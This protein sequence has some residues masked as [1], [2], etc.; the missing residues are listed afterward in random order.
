MV[1]TAP[2]RVERVWI[3]SFEMSGVS[4]LGGLGEAVGLL[5]RG[6]ARHGLK[7]TVVMPSHGVSPPGFVDRGVRCSGLRRGADGSHHHYSIGFLEGFVDGVRVLLLHGLDPQTSSILDAWPHYSNVEEK[8]SLL[9]RGALCLVGHEGFPDLVHAN[10]WHAVP[11]AVALKLAAEERGYSLPTVFQVHLR[12]SASFPWHYASGEWSG[13]PNI[14]HRVWAVTHHTYR[15]TKEVWDWCGGSVECF[16]IYEADA[17]VAVSRSVVDELARSYGGWLWG[18]S[19]YSYNSTEWGV[20]ELRQF[21]E[22][23]YGTSSR[24]V[25]RWRLVSEVLESGE[26]WGWLNLS[27][28]EVLALSSGR[29]TSQK[30]F[31]TLLT[32]TKY[33]PPGVRVLI[34]GLRVGSDPYEHYVRELAEGLGGRAAVVYRRLDHMIYKALHYVAHLYVM[35][36]RYEPFGISAI[37]AMAVG[38][39]I[40]ATD[41]GG[42]S[43]YVAD[44][45][46]SPLGVGL[47][48]PPEDPL[49]LAKAI[50]SL[51]YLMHISEGGGGLEYVTYPE[52]R[53]IAA[54]EPRYGDL[55]RELTARYVEIFFRPKH[56][57]NSVLKC[58]ELARNMAYYRALT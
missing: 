53:A 30:G 25:I 37:E 21:L 58:Y 1:I 38:T 15:W 23:R 8:A 24:S 55:L 27:G 57:V 43:E 34:L 18:K 32:A 29:I 42:P 19:C 26:V 31:D 16:G 56:T 48:V 49:E 5:A 47:K 10:D 11:A 36:S 44:L 41:S 46:N 14:Q 6:L 4:K 45:R 7:V 35:P 12:S 50:Q 52:L 20:D 33:L 13:L 9:T 28:A 17:V 51:G 39:P 2:L 54:R 40:V 3:F 22:G